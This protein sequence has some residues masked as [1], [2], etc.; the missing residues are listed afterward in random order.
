MDSSTFKEQRV[1][2]RIELVETLRSEGFAG[3]KVIV[4]CQTH[5]W[6]QVH[7]ALVSTGVAD[8]RRLDFG[9]AVA[10]AGY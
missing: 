9:V 4:S 10:G 1:A 2:A 7:D 8:V 6:E 5:G 3:W